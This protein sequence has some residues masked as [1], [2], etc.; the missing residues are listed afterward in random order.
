MARRA[1]I[2]AATSGTMIPT[3]SAVTIVRGASSAPAVGRPKPKAS[4]RPTTSAANRK[5]PNSP[6][7]EATTAITMASPSTPRSSWPRLA[8]MV[9]SMASSRVRWATVIEKTLKMM[10]APTSTATAARPSSTGV[11]KPPIASPIWSDWSS[12]FSRPVCT[13]TPSGTTARTRSASAT[14]EIPSSAAALIT[15]TWP[16]RSNQRW[17]SWSVTTTIVAPPMAAS[18]WKTP[19]IVTGRRPTLVAS[20]TFWPTAR[21]SRS[22]MSSSTATS[23]GAS[24]IEP[25]T[26]SVSPTGSGEEDTTSD[27]APPC[28]PR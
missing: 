15:E 28:E 7:R 22:A 12:A 18:M 3:S 20:S 11:M 2:R 21:S 6:S 17:A 14:G 13:R 24:G 16:S 8:P 4:N 19:E 23:P 5:P 25:S 27:G 1:G 10:N 26:T 9:R